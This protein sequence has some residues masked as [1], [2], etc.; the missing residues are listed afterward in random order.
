M[1][2]ERASSWSI[3]EMESPL[4]TMVVDSV[5]FH[6]RRERVGIVMKSE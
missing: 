4:L 6:D 3:R 2:L 1:K 5:C